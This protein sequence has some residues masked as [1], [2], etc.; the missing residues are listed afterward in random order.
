M[1]PPIGDGSTHQLVPDHVC[2]DHLMGDRPDTAD[3]LDPIGI[4]MIN[5]EGHPLWNGQP[6][7]CLR[8]ICRCLVQDLVRLPQFA[9]LT[10]EL[11]T[12]S[13]TS[14]GTLPHLPLS[15]SAVSP[16]SAASGERSRSCQQS[17]PRWTGNP[18]RDQSH[19]HR[20]ITGFGRKPLGRLARS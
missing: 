13:A 1:P 16:I 5:N 17:M 18:A 11:L 14:I 6:S 9:V 19:L 2:Q 12:L 15:T 8:K 20:S 3:R 7:S 10:R 4:A